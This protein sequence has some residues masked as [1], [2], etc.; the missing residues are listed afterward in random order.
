MVRGR[1]IDDNVVKRVSERDNAPR[2]PHHENDA[3]RDAQD[4]GVTWTVERGT[5]R[6]SRLGGYDKTPWA[7]ECLGVFKSLFSSL[8]PT[9]PAMSVVLYLFS[10]LMYAVLCFIRSSA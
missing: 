6:A 3:V 1:R 10:A 8:Q 5:T 9:Q 4:V 2:R 7:R